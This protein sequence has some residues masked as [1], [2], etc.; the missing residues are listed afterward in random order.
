MEP[1][2]SVIIVRLGKK[3]HLFRCI[4]SLA[5]QAHKNLEIIIVTDYLPEVETAEY[6]MELEKINAV[7]V[8]YSSALN[9]TEAKA[10]GISQMDGKYF[11]L[12][13]SYS[14][15]SQNY[16]KRAI[17]SMDKEA[18]VALVHAPHSVMDRYGARLDFSEPFR[19]E[20]LAWESRVPPGAVMRAPKVPISV[21]T[22]LGSFYDDVSIWIQVLIPN[23][24]VRY[25]PD[26]S[27]S[28]NY[29]HAAMEDIYPIPDPMQAAKI[30]ERLFKLHKAF[31]IQNY[32]HV[33]SR[34]LELEISWA[35]VWQAQQ[36]SLKRFLPW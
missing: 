34:R 10:I 32:R 2:V 36:R 12:I 1:L 18:D 4:Q 20:M 14:E 15:L 35:K 17:E 33:V 11:L 8:I 30:H 27:V 7:R 6:L 22:R 23:Y 31:F 16:I 13:E 21:D 29:T 9:H 26:E 5:A 24:E 19:A 3:K 25:L 28:L